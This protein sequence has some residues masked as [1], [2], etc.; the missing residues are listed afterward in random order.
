MAQERNDFSV[1]AII[2]KN[3]LEVDSKTEEG[4]AGEN[5]QIVPLRRHKKNRKPRHQSKLSFM[6]SS[7]S[8]Q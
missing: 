3:N 1:N 8:L 5:V 7:I 6:V 2:F 4:T